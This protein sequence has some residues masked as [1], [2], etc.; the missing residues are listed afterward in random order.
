L[1]AA[2]TSATLPRYLNPQAEHL[3]D[4]FHLAMRI[5]VLTQLAKGPRCAPRMVKKQQMGGALSART[6]SSCRFAPGCSTSPVADDYRR[7]YRGF[8]HTDRQDQAA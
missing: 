1:T 4:W 6:S 7:W 5:T 2:T 3:L 8:T